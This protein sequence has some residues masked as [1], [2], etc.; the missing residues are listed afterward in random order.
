LEILKLQ[1]TE[2][3]LW[4][5]VPNNSLGVKKAAGLHEEEKEEEDD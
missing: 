3:A 5:S 4:R 1:P 2:A